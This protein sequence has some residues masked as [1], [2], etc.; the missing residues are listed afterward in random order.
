MAKR[1]KVKQERS[2]LLKWVCALL[3]ALVLMVAL[4]VAIKGFSPGKTPDELKPNP[5]KPEDFLWENG[6]L[7]CLTRES[8]PGIDVSYYQGDVDWEQVRSSG[9]E[10]AF[11]RLGYRGARDGVLHEDEK[12]QQNLQNARAAGVKVGAYFFSQ[13]LT[14]EE[15]REEAA[16]ALEILKDFTPD[17]PIAYDWEYMEGTART[18]GMTGDALMECVHA[19]CETVESAGYDPMV[20]F[21]LD[22]SETLLDV[23]ELSRYPFWFAMYDTAPTLAW[24]PS[25]WQ[26]TDEGKVPG[27]EGDVD[28]NLYFP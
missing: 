6:R 10:F 17:L 8:V 1:S 25:Y 24:M 14:P 22:L 16:Y 23:P 21:N 4:A 28:L 18:D 20:Y 27:I 5:L 13:A 11:I 15:A 2:L 7:T 3:A 19:F 9:V 12:A 26:Y